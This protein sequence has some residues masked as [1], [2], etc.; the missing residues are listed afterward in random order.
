MKR[1]ATVFAALHLLMVC[2]TAKA[3]DLQDLIA[4]LYEGDGITLRRNNDNPAF[5]HHAHFTGASLDRLQAISNVISQVQAPTRAA[6]TGLTFEFDPVLDDFVR[7]HT[8]LGSIIGERP[9]TIGM[10]RWSFGVSFSHSEYDKLNGQNL[11]SLQVELNHVDIAGPGPAEP[12]VS[13]PPP[14]CYAFEKD[15]IR[16]DMD[17]DIESRYLAIAA[18]YGVSSRW[19]IGFSLPI[20]RNKIK[21]KSVASIIN[22]PS[23]QYFRGHDLH[24][25]DE[26][27]E[28]HRVDQARGSST[29]IGDFALISKYALP[30]SETLSM[31]VQARLRAPTGDHKNLR[32]INQYGGDLMWIAAVKRPLDEALLT[33]RGNLGVG[34]NAI[35]GGQDIL[36]YF[37]GIEYDRSILG[38]ETGLSAGIMG[39]LGASHDALASI[40]RHDLTL[41]F[42]IRLPRTGLASFGLITPLNKQGLRSTVTYSAGIE[43]MLH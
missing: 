37:A 16:L 11:S 13:G 17:I 5:S 10:H 26:T 25:F 43:W 2:Q 22:D 39:Q 28:D 6:A 18:Q 41:G 4:S 40:Q 38:R 23:I 36:S 27:N 7:S 3:T 20:I 35:R 30:D 24:V 8:S 12:C 19:D 29:G 9:E 14:N 1:I 34:I 42:K 33:V 15:V 31:A 32:G 21:I